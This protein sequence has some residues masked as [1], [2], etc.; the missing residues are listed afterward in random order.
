MS[1]A[2][3]GCTGEITD[4]YCNT[5]GMAPRGAAPAAS[6]AGGVPAKGTPPD[7]IVG[8]AASQTVSQGAESSTTALRRSGTGRTRG[9][10]SRHLG[11]GLVEVPP[12]PYRDPSSAVMS[13][14]NVAESHR[15][16]ASCRDPVGRGRDGSP[17]RTEGFCRTCGSPFSFIPK[18]SRGD[19]V[20]AQYEVVGCLAHGGLGWIYLAK[21]RNVADRWVVLKGLLDSGDEDAMA[22]ALAERR[23]LAEVE[24]PNIVKIFN[25]VEHDG[26]GYIVMEYVG[27]ASLKE[28]LSARREANGD[29]SD[30]FPLVQAI[31]YV[32]EILPALGYLHREGLLFCDFKPDNVIQTQHSLKLIDLGGVYRIDDASSPVYGTVGY[33][34]PEIAD[35]GPSIASDLFTVAR[36]LALLCLDFKGYQGT[37]KFTL[38]PPDTTALFAR[39]DSLYRFLCKGTAAN[40]DDRFQDAAEMSDQLFGVLR[41]VLAAQQGTPVPAPSTL[42][43]GDFRA[44]PDRP[45]WRL[46]P[47]PQVA[48]E[49]PAAGYLATLAAT[50][51]EE[52]IGLLRAAPQRTVEVDLR[53]AHALIEEGDFAQA[54]EVLAAVHA[55]DPWE[56]RVSWYRGVAE[57]AQEQPVAAGTSF[58]AVYRAVPGELA[59]KLALA[60]AAEYSGE[61]ADAAG[62]YEIVSRTD[63]GYTTATFGLARCRLA[64]GDRAGALAAYDRIPESSSSHV[65]AQTAKIKCLLQ[66]DD[67]HEPEIVELQAAGASIQALSLDG[68]QRELLT[69]DLLRSALHLLENDKVAEDHEL[70][71]AGNPLTERDVRLGLERTYRSLARLAT[72]A[73]QR[74]RLVDWANR[75]RPRTW[76]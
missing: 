14:A 24:H 13:D 17:G 12:V 18:L 29:K 37:F 15:F 70:R 8:A 59:P 30:P 27:G 75:V 40:P 58:R 63:P 1:C 16:C 67:G 31:A 6:S 65:E 47:A 36:T 52:L 25:F 66:D 23:F 50:D 64:C 69:A 72:T 19:V 9:T 49:D 55:S 35:A 60:L 51:P 44:R 4:G 41:E 22:A 2:Q 48:T 62:W 43:T 7:R 11:A 57:L 46:L 54:E 71:L 39:F 76:T 28:L 45:D 32:M 34:A 73:N 26:S 74:I 5:C 10:A 53:L 68:E 33:Q 38:P 21:D 20:A 42:F 56:W 61:Q 3:P